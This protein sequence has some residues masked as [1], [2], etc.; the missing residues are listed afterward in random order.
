LLSGHALDL[1]F[2]ASC[3]LKSVVFGDWRE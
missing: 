2:D 1:D 3:T